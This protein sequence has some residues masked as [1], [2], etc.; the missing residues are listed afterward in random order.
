GAVLAL[1]APAEDAA[2]APDGTAPDGAVARLHVVAGPDAGGVHLLHPGDI[3]IGRS[4]DADVPLDDPDVSRLHCVV[5]VADDGRVR[6]ADLGSTNGTTVDGRAVGT[7]PVRLAPGALLR[8]GESALR[9]TAGGADGPGGAGGT[10]VAT[11]PD[12][13]GHMRVRGLTGGA[14][15]GSPG[16]GAPGT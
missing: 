12:G 9:L 5:T 6:V 2:D 15:I 8:L 14:G 11:A 7:R 3:R 10:A 1:A 13:E 16:G 4:A